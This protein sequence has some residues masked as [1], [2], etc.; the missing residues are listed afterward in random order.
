MSETE[1][2]N[3]LKKDVERKIVEMQQELAVAREVMRLLASWSGDCPTTEHRFK[4]PL[5]GDEPQCIDCQIQYAY[6]I[7][8]K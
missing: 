6:K 2:L 7:I 3:K 1:R 4:C 5:I 8:K